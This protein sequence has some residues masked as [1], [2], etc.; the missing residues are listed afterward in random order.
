M[1]I[2]YRPHW[3]VSALSAGL[4]ALATVPPKPV[5]AADAYPARPLRVIVNSAPGGLT[6]VVAR[7]LATKMSQTL[8]QPML[9]ENRV[10]AT[11]VL[12]AD[13]VAKAAPDGYTVGVFANGISTFP[14]LFA[15]MPF[16]TDT[17]FS[18]VVLINTSPLVMVTGPKSPYK[19]VAE[20]VSDARARPGRLAIASGGNAT[21]THLIAEQF[22]A[23]AGIQLIHVP[24]KG[25][26]PALNDVMAGHVPAYFDTLGTTVPQARVGTV[27]ALAV[28][29]PARLA[30]LPDVPTLAESGYPGVQGTA[31]FAMF[32]PAGTP[33]EIIARLNAEANR[34]LQAPDI[35]ERMTGS[36]MLIE[37][38]SQEVLADLMR[39]EVPRWAKLVKDRG[40]K[41]E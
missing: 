11:G 23:N 16:N 26:G 5:M 3:A 12:G 29:S 20:Y 9:V 41:A 22:Q 33:P 38:G 8:G 19:N 21:M 25:G 4:L 27:R 36:G 31:W 13:A 6:D 32:V 18:P 10:G 17:A 1:K 39:R 7:V 37:G 24:Y 30:V 34:A 15:S 28:V 14:A 2:H 40:I 35:K